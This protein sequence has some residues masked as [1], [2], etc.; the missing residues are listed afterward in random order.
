LIPSSEHQKY[1]RVLRCLLDS[2]GL[3]TIDQIVHGASLKKAD[4]A[5]ALAHFAEAGIALDEKGGA[6]A[7]DQLPDS[8]NPAVLLCGLGTRVMGQTIHS[9]KSVGST[10]ETARR[11]AE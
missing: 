6:Y 11:L 3:H 10:N 5:A 9:Y 7:I 8:V 2:K 4:V 1:A